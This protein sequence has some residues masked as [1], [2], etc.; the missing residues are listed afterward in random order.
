MDTNTSQRDNNLPAAQ[1]PPFLLI[2]PR[3]SSSSSA[4]VLPIFYSIFCGAFLFDMLAA[5]HTQQPP[6]VVSKSGPANADGISTK[7]K[8][9]KIYRTGNGGWG[10]WDV[11]ACCGGPT[12]KGYILPVKFTRIWIYSVCMRYCAK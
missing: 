3:S 12:G 2:H 11:G 8:T 9:Q 4:R 7:R 1:T 10:M 5:L 6:R